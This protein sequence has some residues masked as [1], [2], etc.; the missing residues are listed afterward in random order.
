MTK[1]RINGFRFVMCMGIA[2][3]ALLSANAGASQASSNQVRNAQFQ[4]TVQQQQT[5]SQLQQSQLQ[6]QLRQNVADNARLPSANDKQ[7]Q[8]QADQAEQAQRDRDRAAQ[9][10]LLDRQR[11]ASQLPRVV[12]N[13]PPPAHS[14]N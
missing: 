10:D 8:K 1:T 11:D 2:A 6:A 7:A 13:Q 9:Q 4:Q 14:N 12:P 3:A 5:N